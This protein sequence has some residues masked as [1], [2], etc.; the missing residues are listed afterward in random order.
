VTLLPTSV[1]PD[2]SLIVLCSQSEVFHVVL[3]ALRSDVWL[4]RMVGIGYRLARLLRA[5]EGLPEEKM[6]STDPVR[7]EGAAR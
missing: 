4:I 2:A 3:F 6:N 7:S 1:D 5:F